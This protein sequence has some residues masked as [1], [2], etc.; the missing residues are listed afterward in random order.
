MLEVDEIA[1]LYTSREPS[2]H[3]MSAATRAAIF[4]ASAPASTA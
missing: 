4:R 1:D 2:T 3:L